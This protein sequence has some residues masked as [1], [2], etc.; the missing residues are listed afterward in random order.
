MFVTHYKR[1]WRSGQHISQCKLMLAEAGDTTDKIQLLNHFSDSMPVG[2]IFSP[3]SLVFMFCSQVI[4]VKFSEMMAT[5]E[6]CN[7]LPSP[8]PNTAGQSASQA[9]EEGAAVLGRVNIL[10]LTRGIL[11][12]HLP[13]SASV[14]Q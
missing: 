6:V 2:W 7:N 8:A 3:E 14:L 9:V 12:G 1:A 10:S 13:P 11:P 4:E 5:I